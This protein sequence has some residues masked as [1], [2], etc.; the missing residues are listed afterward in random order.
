MPKT[1]KHSIEISLF[2]KVETNLKL[3]KFTSS[4]L[5][6]LNQHNQGSSTSL[7]CDNAQALDLVARLLVGNNKCLGLS[8]LYDDDENK[9]TL[10]V[11]T[12]STSDYSEKCVIFDIFLVLKAKGPDLF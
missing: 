3:K 8:L 9:V 4:Y 12:N 5:D 2:D 1:T 10:L 6:R 7:R 11:A